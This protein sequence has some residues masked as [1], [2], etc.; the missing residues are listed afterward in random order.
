MGNEGKEYLKWIKVHSSHK[1][2]AVGSIPCN[3]GE[4]QWHC[5]C[6][7]RQQKRAHCLLEE[8][9]QDLGDVSG[10]DPSEGSLEPMLLSKEDKSAKLKEWPPRC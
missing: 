10:S 8:E 1:V 3:P 2:A 7:S 9:W 4:S 5:N 6:S